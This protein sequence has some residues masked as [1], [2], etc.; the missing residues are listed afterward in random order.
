MAD[1]E[2]LAIP[3]KLDA[4]ILN[5]AVC[6]GSSTDPD[7]D[8]NAGLAKIA[9]LTQPNYSALRFD[10]SSLQN[11]T[12]PFADLSRT[13][14]A[15]FNARLTNPA[16]GKPYPK[17]QGVYLHWLLPKP[18]RTGS[19]LSRNDEVQTRERESMG[20][21]NP[22]PGGIATGRDSGNDEVDMSAA[23][24][25]T[26]PTRWLVMR[27]V[28]ACDPPNCLLDMDAWVVESDRL[29]MLDDIPTSDDVDLEV[30]YA[31]YLVGSA[32]GNLSKDDIA[33][34]AEVFIGQKTPFYEW[35]EV[36]GDDTTTPA[37]QRP[38][39]ADLNVLN[40]SNELFA[41]F[42]P[43][44]SNVFSIVDN[45]QGNDPDTGNVMVPRSATLSYYVLGWHPKAADDPL[46]KM[47]P[48]G[49]I[50]RRQRL[51]ALDMLLSSSDGDVASLKAWLDSSA[52]AT[53][54]CHGT[55]YRVEWSASSKPA[56]V[57][58]D[59]S[60]TKLSATGGVSVG[61]TALDAFIANFLA[62]A[63]HNPDEPPDQQAADSIKLS[64]M[65]KVA[66]ARDA[67]IDAQDEAEDI[68]YNWNYERKDGGVCYHLPGAIHSKKENTTPQPL[69]PPIAERLADLE[70]LNNSQRYLNALQRQLQAGRWDMFASWWRHISD[71]APPQL[72]DEVKTGSD[73]LLAHIAKVKDVRAVVDEKSGSSDLDTV[74]KGVFAPFFQARDP[75]IL[76][77]GLQSGWPID[78]Q[79]ALKVRLL[80]QTFRPYDAA[81]ASLME[82]IY[83]MTSR[84]P[85]SIQQAATDLAGE[86]VA[87]NPVSGMQNS[88][89]LYQT[90]LYHDLDMARLYPDKSGPWR[91]NFNNAQGWFPLFLEWE[92]EYTNIPN[93]ASGGGPL[94]TLDQRPHLNSLGDETTKLRYGIAPGVE[95]S[96]ISPP[97]EDKR[98]V[99]GRVLLLPQLA[100]S[101]TVIMDKIL[102]TFRDWMGQK[103]MTPEEENQL[104]LMMNSFPY[105]SAPLAG[106]RDHLLTRVQGHHIKPNVRLVDGKT[107]THSL[108]PLDAA[109]T[110]DRTGAFSDK[111]LSIMAT[112]TALTPYGTLVEKLHP[113]H[114]P[115]KPVT[116][117]QFRFTALNV[118][119]K[120]G[121]AVSAI[122]PRTTSGDPS[123]L[124][125]C[126]SEFYVPTESNKDPK[127]ANT[128]I[129]DGP[130]LCQYIQLTPAINQPARLNAVFVDYTDG[131]ATDKATS[132]GW[133][134]LSDANDPVWGWI[135]PNY[136][137][138]GIQLFL[139]DGTFFRE[140]RLGGPSGSDESSPWAPFAPPSSADASQ[141]NPKFQQL[142]RLAQKLSDSSYLRSFV[143]MLDTATSTSAP[144][145]TA[146]AEFHSSLVGKPL[147][148]V[149]LGFSLELA[150]DQ[151]RN[152]S[153]LPGRVTEPDLPL[154]LGP[155]GKGKQYKF[156]MQLGDA[157]RA[158]DGLVGYFMPKGSPAVGD[159]LELDTIYTHFVPTE[160]N[161]GIVTTSLVNISSANFPELGAFWVNPMADE[162]AL[163]SDP[164]M[165]Y[166]NNW[167]GH[168]A[169]YGAIIDPFVATHA[170]TGILPPAELRLPH[171][172]WQKALER[173]KAFFRIGPILT[174]ADVPAYDDG[175]KLAGDYDLSETIK[176][177]GLAL[178]VGGTKQWA[179]LQPYSVDN[180]PAVP[181]EGGG[182]NTTTEFM[183]MDIGSIDERPRFEKTPY[184]VVEGYLQMQDEQ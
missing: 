80:S 119:D 121:Q 131:Q 66:L 70:A 57:P 2:V 22:K 118:I 71:M 69:Q 88:S 44:C 167:D 170:Y 33:K 123:P 114:C 47:D 112:E 46:G 84:L 113:T 85:L 55:M 155:D 91:D 23:D 115:F 96:D 56:K 97:L 19:T 130:G 65:I 133:H 95:L 181:V 73:A 146:Y 140:V 45:L 51:D 101:M 60:Q 87:L 10:A 136:A 183:A 180:T 128:V 86:F 17:R 24:F 171:W 99:S 4:F 177:S 37:D 105:L 72:Q 106:F 148:L 154:L 29:H 161:G 83:G 175:Q 145:P 43:H 98:T 14:P 147:A 9:P 27:Q 182:Q 3:V 21:K 50:T 34:Q 54:L 20:F 126:I 28:D 25:P 172:T 64:N 61:T 159:T 16:T 52:P 89:P 135:V 109:A 68:L 81:S 35:N 165:A 15:P 150:T 90:P 156:Q 124:Y 143:A 122:D 31:P 110:A 38:A 102:N 5:T 139:P 151:Y 6:G 142:L 129:Q 41:D 174:T 125:P 120:F 137:D 74:Q 164:A 117:G 75:T 169:A 134:P 149:N 77:Q 58:A 79:D 82:P 53:V 11:D 32:A 178:P 144:P 160:T 40:T 13:G 173:M 132:Q 18:Y 1:P 157:S 103:A 104:R 36:D 158:Y 7:Q 127:V 26:P 78:W 94:W 30:D 162:I 12:L 176:G 168:L 153:S 111:E 184:T 67:G 8:L 59:T 107:G 108:K 141:G 100:I 116:H 163:S 39:R 93:E 166:K 179:W 76:L 62:Q 42:Q 138:R 92:A 48:Q 49:S 152:T 63:S